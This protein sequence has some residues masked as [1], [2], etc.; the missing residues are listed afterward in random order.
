MAGQPRDPVH[1]QPFS[2]TGGTLGLEEGGIH[3]WVLVNNLARLAQPGPLAPAARLGPRG[4]SQGSSRGS[5]GGIPSGIS[6]RI[7]LG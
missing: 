4:P 6:R 7:P 1:L 5:P 2:E 3:G